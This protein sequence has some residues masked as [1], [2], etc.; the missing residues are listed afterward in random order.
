MVQFLV[1]LGMETLWRVEFLLKIDSG[2]Q[3]QNNFVLF[4]S[5]DIH[6]LKKKSSANEMFIKSYCSFN[7]YCM[8]LQST[9]SSL[10]HCVKI[11]LHSRKER[12][13]AIQKGSQDSSL[14]KA[15]GGS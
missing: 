15:K 12:S 10:L 3:G 5:P 7:S 11:C 9:V 6:E 1:G 13:V 2:I 14:A 4:F 8:S